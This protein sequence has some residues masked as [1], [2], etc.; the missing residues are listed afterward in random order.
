MFLS[1]P[2]PRRT[3]VAGLA[4]PAGLPMEPLE[5]YS[6]RFTPYCLASASGTYIQTPLLFDSNNG[7]FCK[8]CRIFAFQ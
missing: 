1:S 4:N 2:W 5:P 8:T 7:D 3:R 6:Y